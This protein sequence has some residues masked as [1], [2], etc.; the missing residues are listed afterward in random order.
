MGG[1]QR[2]RHGMSIIKLKPDIGISTHILYTTKCQF[3]IRI[4]RFGNI[5]PKFG[6]QGKSGNLK[7]V[8]EFY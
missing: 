4:I 3:N 5:C 6:K 2:E 8:R 1:G 7:N